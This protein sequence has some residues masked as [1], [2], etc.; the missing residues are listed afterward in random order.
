LTAFNRA[1]QWLTDQVL[2]SD[3]VYQ[4][5]VVAELEAQFGEEC[6]YYNDGGNLAIDKRVLKEFRKL[7]QDAFVWVRR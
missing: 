4:E 3:L 2:N 7:T 6:V 1:A 5:E